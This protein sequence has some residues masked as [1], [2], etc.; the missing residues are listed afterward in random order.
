MNIYLLEKYIY[1]NFLIY[2]YLI[3]GVYLTK[4]NKKLQKLISIFVKKYKYLN[5]I[6][7]NKVIKLNKWII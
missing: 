2:N 4:C 6:S 7:Y 1:K 5:K 3:K